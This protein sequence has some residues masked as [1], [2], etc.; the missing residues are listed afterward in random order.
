MSLWG[1]ASGTAPTWGA[2]AK[3]VPQAVNGAGVKQ[4]PNAGAL[5][6]SN[7]TLTKGVASTVTNGSALGT[8]GRLPGAA[9]MFSAPA[10]TKSPLVDE[11][12]TG[13]MNKPG[14]GEQWF[15][16]HQADVNRPLGMDS[17]MNASQGR[18]L[19][20][21][22]QPTTAAGAFGQM[23]SELKNPTQGITNAQ[24]VSGQLRNT[25]AG[26]GMMSNAA[27]MLGGPNLAHNYATQTAG[28]FQTPGAS[29]NYYSQMAPGLQQQGQGEQNAYSLLGQFA[30]PGAAEGNLGVTDTAL[31]KINYG[32]MGIGAT[33]NLTN[34]AAGYFGQ[35]LKD[36][37]GTNTVGQESQNF[38]PG[39]REL[40][41]SEQLYNSGNQGL[42]SAYAR[43]ADKRTRELQNRMAATGMFGSGTTARGM[44][45]VQADIAASQARDMASLASQAD[46]ARLGR[47]G[48]ALS[49]SD[50][51]GKEGLSRLGL[52][53]QGA[54]A[55]DASNLGNVNAML[56]ATGQASQEALGKVG[57]RTTAANAAEQAQLDRLFKSGQTGL[58]ADQQG[59]QRTQLGGT[60]AHN[61][62]ADQINRLLGGSTVAAAGDQSQTNQATALGGIG[63]NMTQ[64]E[65]SRLNTSGTL[66]IS[67]D[68]QRTAQLNTLMQGATSLD[69]LRQKAAQLGISIEDLI[70]RTTQSD[71][72]LHLAQTMQN[73][74]MANGVQGMFEGRYQNQA[75]N[76]LAGAQAQSGL[77]SSASGAASDADMSLGRDLINGLIS[78]AK[79]TQQQGDQLSEMM[80]TGALTLTQ[81][82]KMYP[83]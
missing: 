67:A 26:E 38:L 65:I 53:L 25:T 79:M 10:P 75:T 68:A 51:A 3:Q 23:S 48:A 22:Y 46:Q 82:K 20:M 44:E 36:V 73:Q 8:A 6:A 2:W 70:G 31:G 19:G 34:N 12:Q 63:N 41:N 30:A 37:N 52:G 21:N 4:L 55:A 69:D 54:T 39:L 57:A 77:V 66:G 29:E 27:N 49:F 1:A 80:M 15:A 81:L 60:L 74:N 17:F 61:A 11:T 64:D 13:F 32:D 43:E 5:F 76:T 42:D 14:T 16:D 33:Q 35:N 72:Q 7:P 62:S 45:E 18:L 71:D 59:L 40:S 56:G 47:T 58:A 28:Q 78:G 83:S 9:S 24:G 50:A